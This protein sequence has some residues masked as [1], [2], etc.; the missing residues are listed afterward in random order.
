MVVSAT[1]IK[2]KGIQGYIR[3]FLN[4][5]KIVKQLR[6]ADGL[7]FV[8]TKGLRTLTGW[9]DYD[10]MKK[11]RN[12]G[13]H[14]DAMRNIKRIGVGGSV[15]WESETEP[16]WQEAIAKLNSERANA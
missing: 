2:L 1:E 5:R 16:N 12:N 10:S 6:Q 8:K 15:T 9:S 7:I 4:V 13:P 11:F 14:L 3:F